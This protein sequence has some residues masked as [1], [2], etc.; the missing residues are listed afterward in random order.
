MARRSRPD[1][2]VT[3]GASSAARDVLLFVEDLRVALPVGDELFPAVDGVSFSL[4]PGEA[5]ALVGESGCGK[6][7]LARAI[8]G[9]SP[10]GSRVSGNVVFEGR[11]LL[12][13]PERQKNAIRG[14][15]IGLVLQEPASALDPVRTVGAQVVEAIRLH[16]PVSEAGAR[17]L[18]LE[19]LRDVGFP[20]PAAG[21][22]EY[23][24]R[25]SGGLRQRAL[26]AAALAPQPRI[27]IADEPTASLDAT[28]AAQVLEL[29]DALRRQRRLALLL[30]THDLGVVAH[31]ADRAIVLYAG[32]IVEEAG[33]RDL[34]AAPRHPY[35]QGLLASV[36]RLADAQ[37]PSRRYAAIPGS[38]PD[39]TRRP[40]GRCAFAPRCPERF[41]PCEKSEPAL[42]VVGP[43]RARCFLYDP[44]AKSR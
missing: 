26:L 8:L 37:N 1:S 15:Q 18:A 5:V 39:L 4:A 38:I 2:L 21:F 6:S 9:L 31:H 42:Y 16:R 27:L 44:A 11:D 30:V 22:D 13:L 17:A 19:T 7:Q 43:S 41:E 33:V 29:L 23:P 14:G 25:L 40:V 24:H 3:V 10:E 12:A 32:R 28:V 34:F 20:D 35:T 36:P